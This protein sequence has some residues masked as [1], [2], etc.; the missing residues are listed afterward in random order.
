MVDE[1]IKEN[2][3][4]EEIPQEETEISEEIPI[5]EAKEAKE[6]EEAE[7]VEEVEET[8]NDNLDEN[9]TTLTNYED[10][11][12]VEEVKTVI[13]EIK[14]KL[15]SNG[16]VFGLS[17]VKKALQQ[18]KLSKIV[19]SSNLFD[20]DRDQIKHYGELSQIKLFNVKETNEEL[21]LICK[22][23]FNISIIGIMRE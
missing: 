5:E 12:P 20:T 21:G 14:S 23:S 6:A 22:K 13:D 8:S 1:N 15:D 11:E 4:E 2:I 9:E 17:E 16:L 18:G 10:D 19:M 7:E 3:I